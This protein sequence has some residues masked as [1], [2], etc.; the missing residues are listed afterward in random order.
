MDTSNP[1]Y[2]PLLVSIYVLYGRPFKRSNSVGR[3]PEDVVPAEF[4]E[5]H[6]SLLRHRDT[7]FAHTDADAEQIEGLGEA[8]QVRFLVLTEN[9]RIFSTEFRTRPPLF[10]EII[11]LARILED[12]MEYHATRLMRKHVDQIPNR[13][14]QYR[15]NV[16][17]AGEEFVTEVPPIGP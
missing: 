15:L 8:N 10:P 14:G 6:R 2:Y 5:L 9:V 1:I 13:L 7:F 16:R 11:A 17:D 12:K 4:M 3:I